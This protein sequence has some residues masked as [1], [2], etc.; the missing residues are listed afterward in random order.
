MIAN[1]RRFYGEGSRGCLLESL[2]LGQPDG[3]IAQTVRAAFTAWIEAL[4]G[5][6][7][8]AK[9]PAA[10]ARRRAEDFVVR[11]QGALVVSRGVADRGPF[12]RTMSGLEDELL[13]VIRKS[14]AA[15]PPRRPAN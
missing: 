15:R 9:V 6:L 13:E 1:V 4:A 2:S 5:C 11:V 3:P 12:R 10:E 14:Q 7:K 8:S